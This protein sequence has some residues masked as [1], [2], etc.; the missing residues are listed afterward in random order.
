M[1]H[2]WNPNTEGV[3]ADLS[4]ADYHA[5]P[6]LSHSTL[7]NMEPTP[8]HCFAYMQ[9]K[10]EPTPAMIL[11][12]LTHS[13]VL[14]PASPLPQLAVKPE[15]MKFSTTVGK[16]WRAAREQEGRLIVTSD[17]YK[18]LLGMT[19]EIAAHPFARQLLSQGQT[20]LSLF[21]KA[22]FER[23]LLRKC[24]IDFVPQG[25]YLVDVKTCEDASPE[26]F[27]KTLFNFGYFTQAAWYLDLWNDSVPEEPKEGFMFI[28]VEKAPP[29]AAAVYSVA[30]DAIERGR[31]INTIRAKK[32][33]FCHLNNHWPAYSQHW[34]VIDLPRW[35]YKQAEPL[36][37]A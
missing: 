26:G 9:E 2:N 7:K 25:N 31:E 20:E 36:E 29:Y 17:A 13:L 14:E 23:S 19:R 34:S 5:A 35:A 10:P 18:S 16:E 8:A 27:A 15:D 30:K 6:G 37:E 28:A 12:T 21:A 22:P 1:H 4:A 32:W 11:G 33:S 3:F 24:R